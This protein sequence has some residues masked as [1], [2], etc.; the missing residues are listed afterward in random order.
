M[1]I[2]FADLW[3]FETQRKAAITAAAVEC[4]TLYSTGR[5]VDQI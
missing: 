2:F 5:R 4:L 3:N 1:E